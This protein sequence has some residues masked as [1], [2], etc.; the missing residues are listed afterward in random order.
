MIMT[1]IEHISK[2]YTISSADTWE[3]KTITYPGDTTGAFDNDNNKSLEIWIWL[4][5]W[6]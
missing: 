1:T 5:C 2:S 3:K 6:N 4:G